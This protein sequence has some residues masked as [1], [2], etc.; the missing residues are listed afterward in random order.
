MEN[1]NKLPDEMLE[2]VNGGL[3]GADEATCPKCGLPMDKVNNPYGTNMWKC[4]A[5]DETQ[6][7]SDAEYILM[8]KAAEASGQTQGLIYPIW[9]DKIQH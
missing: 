1:R 6:L 5:C 8:L 2:N 4:A 3:G 9:W 7:L